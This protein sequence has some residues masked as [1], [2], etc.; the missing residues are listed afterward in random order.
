MCM[1]MDM[2][3]TF[4]GQGTQLASDFFKGVCDP[5]KESLIKR[6]IPAFK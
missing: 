6:I 1:N 4:L 5:I 3:R 2:F